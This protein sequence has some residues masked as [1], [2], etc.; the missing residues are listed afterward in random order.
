MRGLAFPP[1]GSTHGDREDEASAWAHAVNN[2][3]RPTMSP[4]IPASQNPPHEEDRRGSWGAEQPQPSNGAPNTPQY[5]DD[6]G[7][8]PYPFRSGR[9]SIIQP[10][11]Q[12]A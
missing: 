3:R 6:T 4:S 7:L 2:H 5:G 1:P 11:R 12:Q 10:T 9:G 8:P